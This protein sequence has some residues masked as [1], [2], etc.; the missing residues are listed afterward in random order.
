[1]YRRVVALRG[2]GSGVGSYGTSSGS[3]FGEM[4]G[5]NSAVRSMEV[6]VGWRVVV[7]D[8]LGSSLV[9]SG[10]SDGDLIDCLRHGCVIERV[11]L[12]LGGWKSRPESTAS[13]LILHVG[14]RVVI[15]E[16]DGGSSNS[17]KTGSE[18]EYIDDNVLE[19]KR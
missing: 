13:P 6:T 16:T 5:V 18:D 15:R 17:S 10:V 12:M 4:S 8:I 1:V 14:W 3:G 9:S 19:T 2:T 7:L 11:I